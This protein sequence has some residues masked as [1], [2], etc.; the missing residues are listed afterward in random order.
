VTPRER[1]PRLPYWL[2]FVAATA[3]LLGITAVLVLVVMPQRFVLEAGF[4]ESGI[5]F[6][7]SRVGFRP[8]E[9]APLVRPPPPPP[10]RVEPAEGPAER[11]WREIDPL[12][13]SGRWAEALARMDEYLDANPGDLAVRR[14]RARTLSRAGRTEAAIAAWR[15]IV[16]ETGAPADR[17]ALARTMRDGGDLDAAIDLYGGLVAARPTDRALRAEQARTLLWAQR[18]A[19]AEA[20]LRGL[21]AQDPTDDAARLDLARA[22]Y[23][24]GRP[25][26]A[27]IVLASLA[28]DSPLAPEARTLDDELAS[29]LATPAPPEAPPPTTV[30]RARL[31][32]ADGD[33]D[34]ARR[35]YAEALSETPDDRALWTEWIDFLQFRLED[36]VAARDAML[37]LAGRVDLTGDERFRLAELHAWTGREAEAESIL[38]ALL[39]VEPG[40]ADA[41]AF[42]GDLRRWLGDPV[43]ASRTYREALAA[44]P[45]DERARAGLDSLQTRRERLV[46]AREPAGFGPGV[47]WFADSEDFLRLDLAGQA[48]FAWSVNALKLRAG[49]RRLEGYDPAGTFTT[50]HGGF[51]EIEYARWWREAGLR[52]SVRLGAEG[53]DL[54]GFEPAAALEVTVPDAG[55]FALTGRLESAPAWPLTATY[56]SVAEPVRADR[57]HASAF[58]GL[59]DRWSLGAALDGALLSGGGSTNPRWAGWVTLSRSMSRFLSVDLG[60]SLSGFGEAAPAP[61]GRRLYWDPRLFWA[62]TASLSLSSIPDRGWGWRARL[63]GGAAYADERDA[64]EPGWFPQYGAEGGVVLRGTGQDVVLDAFYRRG[65]EQEYSS[66]GLELGVLL[67]P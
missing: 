45:G 51:G 15:G 32:T 5:T 67:R 41:L 19:D 57:L 29:V 62:T 17:L 25:A 26:E 58:R 14:E 20:V 63:T 18:Y 39:G 52:T 6:P 56:E 8:P 22:L 65:R 4:R 21:L 55:G 46:V 28:A 11:L 54:A 47:T 27:R 30:E 9:P 34:R 35:L 50:D 31:A 48:D 38:E 60:T 1:S 24:D 64:V 36:P 40:R 12:L 33:L 13:A 23:W 3:V 2:R 10:P 61:V 49:Y 44:D 16:R 53:L 7:S 42:L 66:W 37:A 43:S 59:G